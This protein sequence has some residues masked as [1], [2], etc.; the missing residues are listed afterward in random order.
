[1]KITTST[2]VSDFARELLADIEKESAELGRPLRLDLSAGLGLSHRSRKDPELHLYIY[3]PEGS[4]DRYD[5]TARRPEIVAC[6]ASELDR[7]ALGVFCALRAILPETDGAR[8]YRE[9]L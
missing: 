4:A 2:P 6:R 5:P 8:A 7:V 9:A 1:M 3:P